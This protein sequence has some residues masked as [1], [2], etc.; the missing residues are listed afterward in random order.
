MAQEQQQETTQG[1][2][3]GEWNNIKTKDD[4][5]LTGFGYQRIVIYGGVM[6]LLGNLVI[7]V[8]GQVAC[9]NMRGQ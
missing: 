5:N 7:A 3:E 2:M 1:E 6:W 4:R 9:M 8:E